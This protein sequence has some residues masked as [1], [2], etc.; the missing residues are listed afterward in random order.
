MIS[1][2]RL[3]TYYLNYPD[4][5][6]VLSDVFGY[7]MPPRTLSLRERL[8]YLESF[9]DLRVML[10][11]KWITDWEKNDKKFGVS[12]QDK[13]TT[14]FE[15][16]AKY[17]F[18]RIAAGLMALKDIEHFDEPYS[19]KNT[20]HADPTSEVFFPKLTEEWINNHV[21]VIGSLGSTA[22]DAY[23]FVMK[24][25]V[26]L[27]YI[28]R[29]DHALLTKEAC[30]TLIDRG[31]KG[32]LSESFGKHLMFKIPVPWWV[33]FLAGIII[34]YGVFAFAAAVALLPA[35]GSI[36]AIIT[37]AVILAI[38]NG[39][40]Y[41]ETENHVLI[42]YSSIYLAR[43]WVKQNPRQDDRFDGPIYSNVGNVYDLHLMS[44]DTTDDLEDEGNSLVIVAHVGT[45]LHIRIFDANGDKV[46]D[47][48]EN[49]LIPGEA[50]TALKERLS[51]V[52]DESSLSQADKQEIIGY[53]TSSAGHTLGNSE[54]DDQI[55]DLLL[56]ASGRVLHNGFFE[57]SGRP[58]QAFSAHPLLCLQSFAANEQLRIGAGNALDFAWTSSAFRSYH[59]RMYSPFRRNNEKATNVSFNESGSTPMV[60]PFFS[61]PRPEEPVLDAD[62]W[63]KV[64]NRGNPA[65]FT[66]WAMLLN[67]RPHE[68]ITDF[69]IKEHL[70]EAD[71]GYWVR[72]QSRY[73]KDH[74]K[75]GDPPRYFDSDGSAFGVGSDINSTPE[76]CFVRKDFMN[77]GGGRFN[78]YELRYDGF[79]AAYER[80]KGT[81]IP[82]GTHE[83]D[84]IARPQV[85]FVEKA[86]QEFNGSNKDEW[87]N[88]M[89]KLDD[90]KQKVMLMLGE[91]PDKKKNKH[92]FWLADNSGIYKGFSYGY[93]KE[94]NKKDFHL[95]HPMS[96]PPSWSEFR[97]QEDGKNSFANSGGSR[98]HFSFYDLEVNGEL[99]QPYVVIARVSKS[100]NRNKYRDYARGFWELVPRT[101]FNSAKQLKEWV[102]QNNPDAQF[103]NSTDGNQRYYIY[104]MTTGESLQL[105]DLVGHDKEANPIRNI[106]ADGMIP[107]V[108]DPLNLSEFG[109]NHD[110]P[111]AMPLLEVREVDNNS[112]F[113]K[114]IYAIAEG[115]GRLRVS[116]PFMNY[117]LTFDSQNY[118][119]P[120]KNGNPIT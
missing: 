110:N 46:V 116:N 73:T 113:T 68:V 58:Y 98:V 65:G 37:P 92:G 82:K 29:D 71:Y 33:K 118:K 21:R 50:L 54:L 108:D 8:R 62:F 63:N 41:P 22:T 15:A 34:A 70:F 77:A 27:L 26:S 18:R 76:L 93:Y 17:S 24:E 114:N 111:L 60:A 74:Y 45:D 81:Y 39:L 55:E 20:T 86:F 104:T 14:E 90:M 5:F 49:E 106:W 112:K 96:V 59:Q 78:R 10:I 72:M 47:R 30:F 67:Y 99:G 94:N 107:L 103:S 64:D 61:P 53:A 51:P 11:Q 69:A 6:S 28:F 102:L 13:N 25:I 84:F 19:I 38:V 89:E 100:K 80:V 42:T 85:A 23:D 3:A 97:Y 95:D 36:A 9:A 1:T 91:K 2:K 56:Q 117:E 32:L 88:D 52:P 87:E 79:F 109:I 7:D 48:A 119:N 40:R 16:I 105:N 101:R 31:F 115:D 83:Y 57:T 12:E 75:E 44:V 4:G 120:S 66:L 43:N 35:L